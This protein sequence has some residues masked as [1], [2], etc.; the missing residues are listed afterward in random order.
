MILPSHEDS[1][2]FFINT[3]HNGSPTFSPFH[4]FGSAENN[5]FQNFLTSSLFSNW[6]AKLT[7][8]SKIK[9]ELITMKIK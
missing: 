2:Y 4:L 1:R 3:L 6:N 7:I 5:I 9:E 8:I